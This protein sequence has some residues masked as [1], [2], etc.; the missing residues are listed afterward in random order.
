MVVGSNRVTNEHDKKP[1]E[2]YVSPENH[3]WPEINFIV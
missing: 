3:W 2:R 1:K